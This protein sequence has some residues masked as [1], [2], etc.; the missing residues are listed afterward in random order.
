MEG[1]NEININDKEKIKK[2]IDE[3]PSAA[4]EAFNIIVHYHKIGDDD[5]VKFIT[6][7]ITDHEV[8]IDVFSYG[9][10]NNVNSILINILE[11]GI[12]PS[13]INTKEGKVK[14]LDYAVETRNLD[15][16]NLLI[17]YGY[18]TPRLNNEIINIAIDN[19][20]VYT[21]ILLTTHGYEITNNDIHTAV[22]RNAENIIKYLKSKGIKF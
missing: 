3:N 17:N 14:T 4:N 21:I 1:L 8:L 15:L 22:I 2:F 18:Y 7:L 10:I 16:I 13:F 5:F 6:N 12:Y 20:N 11:S 9:I 19:D